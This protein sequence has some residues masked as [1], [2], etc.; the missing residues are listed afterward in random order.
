MQ[1]DRYCPDFTSTYAV[2]LIACIREMFKCI[3][4]KTCPDSLLKT[5]TPDDPGEGAAYL[6]G[7]VQVVVVQSLCCVWLFVTLWTTARQASLSITISQS[8]LKLCMSLES[9]M[10]SNHLILCR[11]LLLPQSFPASWSFLTSQI[12]TSGGQSIGASASVL[13]MNI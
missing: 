9:V 3:W 6:W 10:P 12:F 2:L 4:G 8:L 13:P 5:V 1:A 11:P 7:A